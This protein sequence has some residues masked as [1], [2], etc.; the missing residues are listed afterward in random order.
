MESLFYNLSEVEFSR[1]RKALLWIFASLFFLA[2]IGIIF[3]NVVLK[4]EAINISLSSAPFGISIVVGIIAI[5]A[6]F[7]KKGQYFRIDDDNIDFRY[8][9]V[10]PEKQTFPWNNIKEI[11]FSQRQKKIKLVM[12]DNSS[13][14]INLTWIEKKKSSHIRKHLYY[15]A[16]EKDINIIKI[17]TL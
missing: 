9:I 8:G 6:T 5:L 7:S 4:D 14:I 13:Y 15:G 3:M 2:G 17:Q 10:K 11:Y 1:G 16:T 12:K